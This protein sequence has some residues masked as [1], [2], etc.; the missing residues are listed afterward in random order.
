MCPAMHQPGTLC[1]E[2]FRSK[3]GRQPAVRLA[4]TPPAMLRSPFGPALTE[5][6]L[7]HRRRMFEFGQHI[8]H[9]ANR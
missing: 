2:C 3:P 6:Q 1:L 5:R 8:T 7:A 9:A 4:G